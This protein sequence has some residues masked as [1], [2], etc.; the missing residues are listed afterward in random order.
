MQNNGDG[1]YYLR[2]A[3]RNFIH[4]EKKNNLNSRGVGD[5]NAKY[6]PLSVCKKNVDK[7]SAIYTKFPL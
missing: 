7:S 5:R 1:G 2:P 3:R 4:W 6:I